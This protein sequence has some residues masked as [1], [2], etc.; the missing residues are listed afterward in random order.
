MKKT[1]TLILALVLILTLISAC[2]GG[3]TDGG[4][5]TQPSTQQSTPP[6][7]QPSAEQPNGAEPTGSILDTWDFSKDETFNFAWA[8]YLNDTNVVTYALTDF[9]NY[10]YELSKGTID[11]TL[12]NSATLSPGTEA[13]DAVKNGMADFCNWPIAYATG[14]MPLGQIL[15]LPGPAWK[16]N[17]AATYAIDEWYRTLRPAEVDGYHQ[18]C[19][20][21]VGNGVF[22]TTVPIRTCD[23]FAGVQIR[24]QAAQ[25]DIM[26]AYGAIPVV[27]GIGEV[28]E[29]M[30]TG[31]IEGCYV[32][33][34]TSYT[35]KL[36]EVVKY[37][38]WAPY[39]LSAISFLMNENSWNSL[40][41]GQ[42]AA[43]DEAA[44]YLL[45]LSAT[46]MDGQAVQAYDLC[47]E[48][49]V[50]FIT[51]SDEE[52]ER[53][54]EMHANVMTDYI[55]QLDSQG[56]DATGALQLLMELADKYNEIY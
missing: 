38:T 45:D 53:M 56:Y 54:G 42:Q 1:L 19:S 7:A 20:Y 35:N 9:K 14:N 3:N 41:E 22:M 43:V 28:Y 29:A 49:G 47:V 33:I 46:V 2:A 25:A 8:N 21:G 36:H 39:F 48:Y 55:A 24:T 23:D 5:A 40:S 4:Q 10:L 13:A 27:M 17:Q 12:Y 51:F 44:N 34:V 31:V 52:I 15:G 37:V 50:E 32:T 30:R 18:L 26:T 6:P 16:N 11:I